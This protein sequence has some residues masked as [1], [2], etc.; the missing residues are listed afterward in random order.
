[1]THVFE[2]DTTHTINELKN[3]NQINTILPSLRQFEAIQQTRLR[4]VWLNGKMSHFFV[5]TYTAPWIIK[6][7][8][9]SNSK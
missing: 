9:K 6:L 2:N 8:K 1:M 7:T 3:H 4:L 5:K